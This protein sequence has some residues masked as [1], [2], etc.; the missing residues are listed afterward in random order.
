MYRLYILVSVYTLTIGRALSTNIT[1][2]NIEDN[3]P[4]YQFPPGKQVVS[5]GETVCFCR[6]IFRLLPDYL[7]LRHVL[8]VILLRAIKMNV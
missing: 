3:R 6:A 1:G 2:D 4:K 5:P 7:T 8:S